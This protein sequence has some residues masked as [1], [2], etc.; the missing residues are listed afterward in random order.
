M[1]SS[2]L[3]Y[4]ACTIRRP[5]PFPTGTF[6][7]KQKPS[8]AADLSAHLLFSCCLSSSLLLLLLLGM[9]GGLVPVTT[10]GGPPGHLRRG[11]ISSAAAQFKTRH[12]LGRCYRAGPWRSNGS[13]FRRQTGAFCKVRNHPSARDVLHSNAPPS[14]TTTIATPTLHRPQPGEGRREGVPRALQFLLH[15]TKSFVINKSVV[16]ALYMAVCAS[17]HAHGRMCTHTHEHTEPPKRSHI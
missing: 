15:H 10:T 7:K 5:S 1:C 4:K 9:R 6:K 12:P 11:R 17:R 14:P 8:T 13:A 16:Y 2:L 3:R